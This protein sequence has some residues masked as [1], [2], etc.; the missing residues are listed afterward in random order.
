MALQHLGELVQSAMI[1]RTGQGAPVIQRFTGP[2]SRFV[3]PDV[4]ELVF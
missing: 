4:F 1:Q 2:G 3:G